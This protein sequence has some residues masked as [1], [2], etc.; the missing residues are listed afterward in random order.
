ME[1]WT[2]RLRHANY[3]PDASGEVGD[4]AAVT[5][6]IR[7]LGVDHLTEGSGEALR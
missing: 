5:G 2:A 7:A 6:G 3:R 1:P 4:A